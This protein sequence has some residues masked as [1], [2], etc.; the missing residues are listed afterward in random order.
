M[1]DNTTTTELKQLRAKRINEMRGVLDVTE[2]EGRPLNADEREKYDKI[3][4]EVEDL[5]STIDRRERHAAAASKVASDQGEARVARSAPESRAEA[6]ET[7]EYR[8]AFD[9]YIR[10]GPSSLTSDESRA[11]QIGTNSEGGFLTETTLDRQLVETLD[12]LNVMRQICTVINTASDR[13]IPVESDAAAATW[14]SEEGAYVLDDVAFSQVSLSAYKLGTIMKISE[15]L[16][17]DSAIFNLTVYIA[18]NFARRLAGAEETA[19][20]TGSGSGQPTGVDDGAT[21]AVTAAATGAVTT[22]ELLDLY[23]SPKRQYR[24]SGSWLMND[25]TI[26]AI[27]Q[28]KDSTNQYL[29]QPGL[30]AGEPD[31]LLGRPVYSSDDMATMAAGAI[32][33]VFGDFSY[34]TIADRGPRVMLRLNELYAANGF[35]AY[36]MHERVDGKVVLAEALQK[37]TMAAS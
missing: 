17:Q 13:N 15:E 16:L 6:L 31:R 28:L 37:I 26:K 22:D 20:V 4:A 21:A 34:Y 5:T 10:F 1:L 14:I 19:F 2:A 8:H 23:H 24:Q 35:V 33:V 11:L 12:E 30:Q 25:A 18:R 27:R 9:R 29:W 36:R 32:A 7:P 3:E